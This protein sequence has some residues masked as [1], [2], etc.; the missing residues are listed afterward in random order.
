MAMA[1]LAPKPATYSDLEAVPPHLVAEI[2]YGTL[3]THPRPSPHHAVAATALSIQLAPGYQQGKGGPGGWLFMSAPELHLGAQVVVPDIAGWRRENLPILPK[4]AYLETA[5]DWICEILSDSTE[6]Y[7]RNAKRR[8]YADAGAAHLWFLDPRIKLLEVF[9][10]TGGHWLLAATFTGYEDVRAAPFDAIA[11][12][13]G[14][15]WPLDPPAPNQ[16][17][18]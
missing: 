7:D 4:T 14:E 16:D 13:L 18:V 1:E 17:E 15:L 3:V 6:R 9:Q 2:I 5:P 11:F 12:S 10:L 8:I